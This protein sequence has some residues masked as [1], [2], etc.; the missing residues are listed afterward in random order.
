M[1]VSAYA[2]NAASSTGSATAGDVTAMLLRYAEAI[3]PVHANR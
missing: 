3:P 2:A 1:K